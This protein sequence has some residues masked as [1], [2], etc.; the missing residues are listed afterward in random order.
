MLIKPYKLFSLV[1][2][3]LAGVTYGLVAKNKQLKKEHDQYKQNT[4]SLLSEIQKI[5]ID[6]TT[7][8]ADVKVLKLSLSE[9]KE[10]R[11][12]DAVTIKKMGAEIKSLQA[13]AKHQLEINAPVDT[14]L[15][16]T[17]VI[18]DTVP[19]TIQKIVVDTPFLKI[20]GVIEENRLTGNIH[21]PVILNQAV[22]IEHKH[23]FLWWKWGVKAIHQTISSNNPHVDIVYSEYLMIGK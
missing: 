7:M 14:E 4:Q 5:R 18:R 20:N 16:D 3:L 19:V 2:L 23:R 12:E 8:A 21:L 6:S 11:K 22:W 17:I 15:K 13:A 10:Y 9:Y 1:I